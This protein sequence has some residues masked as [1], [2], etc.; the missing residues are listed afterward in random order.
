MGRRDGVPRLGPSERVRGPHLP[1]MTAAVRCPTCA[2]PADLLKGRAAAGVT[3]R[4]IPTLPPDVR[5]EVLAGRAD[6]LAARCRALRCRSR[7]VV[8]QAAAAPD[9]VA[10]GEVAMV[11]LTCPCGNVWDVPPAL[12]EARLTCPACGAQEPE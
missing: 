11:R 2:S 8:T 12:A 1:A 3:R 10:V 4:A 7:F 6:L 5:E 9:R